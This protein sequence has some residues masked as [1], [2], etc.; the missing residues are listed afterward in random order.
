MNRVFQDELPCLGSFCQGCRGEVGRRSTN[1]QLLPLCAGLG[2]PPLQSVS[3]NYGASDSDDEH[4]MLTPGRG[5]C[6]IYGYWIVGNG[7]RV[8]C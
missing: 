3:L 1:R 5:Y 2:Q 8:I 4:R 7:S 6:F